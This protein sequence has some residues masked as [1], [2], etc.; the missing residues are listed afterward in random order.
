MA[1]SPVPFF[2][3]PLFPPPRALEILETSES[4][5]E[6]KLLEKKITVICNCAE[7]GEIK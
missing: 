4:P 2:L 6:K 7:K 3:C 5:K 1:F